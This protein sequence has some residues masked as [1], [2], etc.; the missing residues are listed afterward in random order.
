VFCRF[1]AVGWPHI[2]LRLESG[3]KILAPAFLTSRIASLETYLVRVLNQAKRLAHARVALISQDN[4]SGM[5]VT[6]AVSVATQLVSPLIFVVAQFS[7]CSS[8]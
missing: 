1:V 6:V 3:I 4:G 2:K 8:H 7:C 5:D